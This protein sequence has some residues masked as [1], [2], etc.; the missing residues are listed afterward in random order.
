MKRVLLILYKAPPQAD[1]A[2]TLREITSGAEGTGLGYRKT[3]YD[4]S[5]RKLRRLRLIETLKFPGHRCYHYRLTKLG[6]IRAEELRR[7]F[8]A[9]AEEIARLL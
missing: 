7:S 3:T 4:K 6:L 2:M 8:K 1:N 9:M 5:V